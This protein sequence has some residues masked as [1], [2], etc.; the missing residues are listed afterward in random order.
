LVA[1][2][3]LPADIAEFDRIFVRE[4]PRLL[5]SVGLQVVRAPAAPNATGGDQP[6]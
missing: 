1:F 6:D 3:K 5:A 2:E 4:I